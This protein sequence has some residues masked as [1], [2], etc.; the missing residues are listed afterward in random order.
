MTDELVEKVRAGNDHAFRMLIETYKQ[1]IYRTVYSVLRNQ[2]D[3][4]DVTQEVFI[5]IYTS[6]P[7][8]KNQGF[9]TWITRIAVNHAIDLKRKRE[10]QKEELQEEHSSEANL[11]LTDD[12]EAVFFRNERRKQVLRKLND[13]PEG[14]RD[15][16][17]SYYI[18]EKTFKQIAEE[19]HIQVK[20]VEVKLYR[21]RNWMRKHWKKEDFS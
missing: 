21:A 4:E 14:Y 13:L 19:Q 8:Y 2:K 16:V 20:S 1:T 17:Y 9:K 15:V 3:A 18:K 6:L 7:Q 11:G 10:R 5:K 12:V